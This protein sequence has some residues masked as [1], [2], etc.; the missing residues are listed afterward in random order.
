M[1]RVA[2]AMALFAHSCSGG[3]SSGSRPE[4]LGITPFLHDN[5]ANPS[6]VD[7][8]Y[9]TIAGS[10]DMIVH[11]MD[12][13]VPWPEAATDSFPYNSN[14]MDDWGVR[15]AHARAGQ[16][17]YLAISPINFS[18]DGLA[19][20]WDASGKKQPLPFPWSTYTF[21][22][23]NVMSAWL[24]YCKRAVAFFQP[25]FLTIGVEVNMLM[26]ANKPLWSG[27]V[28]L[29]AAT[30]A[31]L[32]ALYPKMPIMVSMTVNEQLGY[33]AANASDQDQARSDMDLV[34]DYYC[35]SSYPYQGSNTSG[36]VPTD[37]FDRLAALTTHPMAVCETG[38]PSQSF[39]Q[40]G[41][42][43]TN[44]ISDLG[45]Q[46]AYFQL[47]FS[48]AH[49]YAF[50]FVNE[51]F[52]EDIDSSLVTTDVTRLFQFDGFLDETGSPKAAYDSWLRELSLPT[53]AAP[54]PC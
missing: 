31:A 49:K 50:K 29:Q 40:V 37:L 42:P 21:N 14:L 44:Y 4:Y 27:Y 8:T 9:S 47:L 19:Q 7:T 18:R 36:V 5:G 15:L 17:V 3:G 53:C 28:E 38:F 45:K 51:F 41:P 1:K 39:S 34:S 12:G 10:A 25:D 43:V 30:Y 33:V 20:L 16:K 11:H 6:T 22:D 52:L 26:A 2:L 35:L 32:K 48:A 54:Y 46:N 23:P 13:G 24:N